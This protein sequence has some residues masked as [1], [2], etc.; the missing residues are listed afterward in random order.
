L[1]DQPGRGGGE[2]EQENRMRIVIVAV[3]AISASSAAASE[4]DDAHRL[5]LQGRDSYWNCLA[6]EYSAPGN[7]AMSEQEFSRDVASVCPSERQNFRVTL[8]DYLTQQYPGVEPEA[9]LA[10]ANRAVE[11]AQKDVVTAF[12]R[13]KASSK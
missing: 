2:H 5:A 6:R 4:L 7:Q 3:T 11:A 9:H 12:V 8:Q 13:H 1:L 10:T